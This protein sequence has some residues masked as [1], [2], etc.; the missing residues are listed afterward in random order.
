MQNGAK[1]ACVVA[2]QGVFRLATAWC[3]SHLFW[4]LGAFPV[5]LFDAFKT[6]HPIYY[7]SRDLASVV[8][9]G[10]R[11]ELNCR[12]NHVRLIVVSGAGGYLV[13]IEMQ[14]DRTSY[15]NNEI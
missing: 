5:F 8:P 2:L 9:H 14:V 15:E 4:W 12:D 3:L 10:D 11:N 1:Q 13:M 7:G 6:V